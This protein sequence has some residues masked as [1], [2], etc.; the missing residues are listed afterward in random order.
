[1]TATE[2]SEQ[3]IEVKDI[4]HEIEEFPASYFIEIL[5]NN[6]EQRLYSVTIDYEYR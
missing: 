2:K 1:M 3:I 6:S 4:D 5:L